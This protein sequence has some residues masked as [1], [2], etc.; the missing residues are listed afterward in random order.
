MHD[1]ERACLPHRAV[2]RT[3]AA[4]CLK[5]LL[6]DDFKNYNGHVMVIPVILMNHGDTNPQ[7]EG[8]PY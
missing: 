2:S 6:M 8:M 7:G 5:A 4:Q 3:L 1:S